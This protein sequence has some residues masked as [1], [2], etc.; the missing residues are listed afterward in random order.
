MNSVAS[1]VSRTQSQTTLP[2]IVP[3]M[4]QDREKLAN[5]GIGLLIAY[6][7][8]AEVVRAA[9]TIFW[10]DEFWTLS[11]VRQPTIAGSWNAL[12]RLDSQ[13]PAFHFVERIAGALLP[14]QHI[15]YRLPS[16]LALCC[17][18]LC[19]FIFVRRRSGAT[20]ALICALVPLVSTL[21]NYLAVE[22]RGYA[23]ATACVAVAL[24]CYQ[25]AQALRW[26]V[27]M[28]LSLAAASAFHYYGVFAV[29]PLALA[30]AAFFWRT[31]QLRWGAWLG[32]AAG[33]LPLVIFWPMLSTL[34][35]GMGAHY[36]RG[37]QPSL[38]NIV[39]VYGAFFTIQYP[40]GLALAAVATLG[41]VEAWLPTRFRRDEL[42]QSLK[43]DEF[44]HERVLVLGLL[45]LP[46][47]FCFAMK[48]V[49]GGLLARYLME[50]VLGFALAV[51]FI[52][53]RLQRN[54]VILAGAMLFSVFA[55]QEANFWVIHRHNLGKV[56]SP[57]AS[58]EDLLNAAGRPDLPVV[59][60]DGSEYVQFAHYAA[61]ETVNRYVALVDA[62]AA[63]TY[64]GSDFVD[65]ELVA[66]QTYSPLQVYEF[67]DFVAKYPQF[68]LYSGGNPTW[69]WWPTRLLDEHYTL[70]LVGM[71]DNDK[72]YLVAKS[73]GND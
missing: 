69:D 57:T 9:S 11:V 62:P 25:N 16:I 20:Y 33:V 44:V 53:P 8:V 32:I 61:R 15:A 72:L 1:R 27:F 31:R 26:A 17:V 58:V 6:A 14:N 49:H 21:Y 71:H 34:G 54:G 37:T 10:P 36:W 67:R 41:V 42:L 2:R 38:T 29:V 48:V 28:G 19:V 70:R 59:V 55:L 52:L 45:A 46:F 23:L 68:F 3:I 7:A 66:L 39:E 73:S 40:M 13:A 22:A 43:D 35:R 5:Y 30:E 65:N 60:S 18:V 63:M 51:G 47:I 4:K 50:T 56:G 64:A 12:R 24:V